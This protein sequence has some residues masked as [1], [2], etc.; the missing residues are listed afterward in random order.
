MFDILWLQPAV[1]MNGWYF[2]LSPFFTVWLFFFEDHVRVQ[3]TSRQLFIKPQWGK[4]H[5]KSY[6]NFST[7]SQFLFVCLIWGW[8]PL[9]HIEFTT[10]LRIIFVRKH[11]GT[12]LQTPLWLPEFSPLANGT[13]LNRQKYAIIQTHWH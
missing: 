4:P 10:Y 1:I 13:D 9:L 11:G 8:C 6:L 2:L 3:E 12:Y 5:L 7:T